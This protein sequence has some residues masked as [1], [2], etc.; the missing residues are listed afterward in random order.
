M[1]KRLFSWIFDSRFDWPE[2][3]GQ[4]GTIL[5]RRTAL[6]LIVGVVG[7]LSVL[8]ASPFAKNDDELVWIASWVRFVLILFLGCWMVCATY[9]KMSDKNR[10]KFKEQAALYKEI[11]AYYREQKEKK[12]LTQKSAETKDNHF[13][14]T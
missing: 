3:V 9:R 2:R 10:R 14:A 13:E 4:I 7:V 6:A 11:A 5:F 1:K 8:L 12:R